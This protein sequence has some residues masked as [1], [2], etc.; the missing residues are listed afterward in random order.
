M[1][2]SVVTAA[3]VMA[4]LS[5]MTSNTVTT[6]GLTPS[7]LYDIEG[8]IAE[9]RQKHPQA[10]PQSVYIQWAKEALVTLIASK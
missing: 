4:Y 8:A 2:R 7:P 6:N 9:I 1:N 10:H 5:H 3:L